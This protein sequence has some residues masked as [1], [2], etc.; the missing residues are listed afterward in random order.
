MKKKLSLLMVALMAIAAF[1]GLR[2]AEEKSVTYALA[3]GDTF[4]SG[5]TVDVK[6]GD[7]VVATI[8]Y[9]EAGGAD[10]GAAAA[11]GSVEGFTAYTAGNGTNG[12]KEKGTWYTITPK[13]DATIDVAVA[14]NADKAFYI[15]EDG[16]ALEAYNGIKVAA[17]Y[18]GTYQFAAK[19]NKAYKVYCAGSKL[20]FYGFKMTWTAE[21]SEPAG[22]VTSTYIFT[23]QKW[24]ATKDGETANWT[25]VKDGAGFNNNS[26]TSYSNWRCHMVNSILCDS[27]T[28]RQKHRAVGEKP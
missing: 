2:R 8:T 15:E 7:D 13:M 23:S 22:D 19:A 10:F 12:N 9:G 28:I 26:S 6:D 27:Q 11:E 17:K 18:Y 21:D 4:T 20:G 1:A 5:Q 16:T 25:S 3:E 14:L 24:A